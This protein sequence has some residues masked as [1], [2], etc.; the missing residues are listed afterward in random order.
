MVGLSPMLSRQ[1]Q[2][3]WHPTFP[4]PSNSTRIGYGLARPGPVRLVIYNTLGQPV[5][6]LVDEFQAAGSYRVRW[7]APDQPGTSLSSGTY[8][9]RLL[10]PGGVETRRVTYLQ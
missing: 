9:A 6:T 4:T 1:I 5:R 3:D 10:Y 2:S 8:L 7:D